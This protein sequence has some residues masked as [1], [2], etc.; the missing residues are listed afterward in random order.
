MKKPFDRKPQAVA[1]AAFAAALF[2]THA[3][4][5][6]AGSLPEVRVNANAENE[7]ATSP[8]TGYRAKNAA[9]GLK[10]DTPLAETPQSVT[11]VTRDQIVDQGATTL[12]DALNYAAGV[13]SDAYGIDSRSDG[14]RIRGS[15][16]DEYL[17]GLRRMFDWY[18]S[19][20]RVDPY[21]LERIEVLRGPSSM[22]FGQG[23]TGGMV[24]MVSKRP[25]AERQGEIGIQLGSWGRK[26]LHADFTGRLTADGQWLYRLVALGRV[27]DTQVDFVNDDRAVLAPSLTWKPN[28]A[29]SLTL[30]ANWQKDK[31]GSTSQFFP[32][33]G[34]L[35]PNPNGPIPMSRFIG[36][37]GQDRYDSER[38]SLGWLFEHRFND[39]WQVRQNVRFS[40][41]DVD[42]FSLYGDS[43]SARGGWAEDPVNKRLLGRFADATVTRA[44]MVATDQNVQGDF[45]TGAAR[46]KLLV[47]FDA[48][49]YTKDTKSF[50]DYPP[51]YGGTVP[52]FDVYNPVYGNY[53]YGPLTDNPESG[54][55]QAGLYIQDQVKLGPWIFVAGLR[56]DRA[57]TTLEGAADEKSSATTKRLAVMHR[58]DSGITPYLSYSE[59][60]SPVAGVNA[61]G[62]RFKPLRGEQWEAGVK[63]EPEGGRYAFNAA[64]YDLKEKNQR[65]PDPTNPNNSLQAGET[66]TNG[67]EL[68]FKGRPTASLDLIANYTYTNIDDTLEALPE[69]N[70]QLWAKQRF[71][72]AGRAGFSAGLGVRH[73]SAFHDGAAPTVPSVTLLD[74]LLAYDTA[75]WRYALNVS[76]LTDKKYVSTCLSRGDCWFGARR[77]VIASVTYRY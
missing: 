36:E 66:K 55:R 56:H 12:Q 27:A 73:L 62:A 71:S 60:F 25:Q 8:V 51:V 13:R 38:L 33:E 43:F 29:T 11:V 34:V 32:W 39:Q 46:H 47:G 28:G 75:N 22:L 44:T 45:S 21:T 41:N 26:E 42:Y 72:I 53:V 59:S 63:Y 18:T 4:A 1:C 20:T 14:T 31:T 17:D 3:L 40:R 19:N 58:F 24:N 15:F 64:V 57:N 67:V 37:P 30:Q 54:V 35:L 48:L 50:I 5:Q 77:N 68:E 74:A 61:A 65:I 70:L 9:T 52:L 16:P 69:H 2:A 23:V 76:N 49:R 10:T 7:T 6:T